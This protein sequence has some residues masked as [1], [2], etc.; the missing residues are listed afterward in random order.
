MTYRPPPQ[1]PRQ[2]GSDIES[3]SMSSPPIMQY[4]IDAS[5]DWFAQTDNPELVAE[6]LVQA[7]SSS[8][9]HFI[10]AQ[11]QQNHISGLAQQRTQANFPGL[12]IDHIMN[13]G[14]ETIRVTAY[15][16][17][18]NPG[19]GKPLI[20]TNLDGY[21]VWIHRWYK[22]ADQ[23]GPNSI[24]YDILV[25]GTVVVEAYLPPDKL[26]KPFKTG[27]DA[28][29]IAI[30]I[31]F[32]PTAMICQSLHDKVNPFAQ[33]QYGGLAPKVT[34]SRSSIAAAFGTNFGQ[35]IP[36]HDDLL[37][38]FPFGPVAGSIITG[39][40]DSFNPTDWA[41]D[42]QSSQQGHSYLDAWPP[43]NVVQIV[44]FAN[45]QNSPLKAT[46][47]NIF[48]VRP[49]A[50]GLA[51]AA[52]VLKAATIQQ[53]QDAVHG[54]QQGQAQYPIDAQDEINFLNQALAVANTDDKPEIMLLINNA[55]TALGEAPP[56]WLLAQSDQI[57]LATQIGA[58][59]ASDPPAPSSPFLLQAQTSAQ[60]AAIDAG[61]GAQLEDDQAQLT[62][63]QT[64]DQDFWLQAATGIGSGIEGQFDTVAAEFYNRQQIR[65]VTSSWNYPGGS[66]GGVLLANDQPLNFTCNIF[67]TIPTGDSMDFD[68]SV[69][70]K[71]KN[72]ATLGETS[73][74]IFPAFLDD[75][76]PPAPGSKVL[77]QYTYRVID[78]SGDNNVLSIG[79]YRSP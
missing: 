26:I 54:D 41:Y 48:T 27:P 60:K 43:I 40:G 52:D 71:P 30:I 38:Y 5:Q 69:V 68:L 29:S 57:T 21:C 4:S 34:P 32:G 75:E 55:T 46:D 67:M 36:K 20:D 78:V 23:V 18:N 45:A 39:W 19:G 61:V 47:K 65:V 70:K 53:A 77:A 76:T 12:T 28:A 62:F 64:Q 79:D 16:Q 51:A 25:N 3:N 6:S 17:F 37:G 42:S 9:D 44:Q 72:A 7:Y 2:F 74:M 13:H 8:I 24:P 66:P 50:A 58:L 56:N 31:A 14:I 59:E 49:N 22:S 73:P 33:S 1:Q 10:N 15:P 35:T 11:R 63:Y